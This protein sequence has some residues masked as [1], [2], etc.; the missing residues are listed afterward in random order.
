MALFGGVVAATF[1]GIAPPACAED[2]ATR[3]EVVAREAPGKAEAGIAVLRGNERVQLLRDREGWSEILLADGRRAWVPTA[4]LVHSQGQKPSAT[5]TP[6]AVATPDPS[7]RADPV[8]DVQTSLV[9]EI[10]R[11]RAVVDDLETRQRSDLPPGAL[12]RGPVTTET[13]LLASGVAFVVG[14]VAGAA[15]QRRRTRRERS[16][17]F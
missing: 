14:V 11:L 2:V 17:R 5:P 1:G 13:A 3:E 10:T 15:W 4:D 6:A 7:P 16:L 8:P 12:E 9:V